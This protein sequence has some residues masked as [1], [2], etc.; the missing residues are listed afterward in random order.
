MSRI[1]SVA[2]ILD[3]RRSQKEEVEMEAK[4]AWQALRDEEEI[5]ASIEKSLSDTKESLVVLGSGEI[6]NIHQLSLYY[7]YI[8]TLDA[9]ISRQLQTI[10]IKNKELEAVQ[11]R[12]VEAYRDMKM[13]ETLKAR[14]VKEKDKRLQKLETR[15]LDSIWNSMVARQ[16]L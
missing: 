14:L 15:Q 16:A 7:E 8:N 4:K 2:R 10:L 11:E 6:S 12:L 9:K 5:L 3:F 13:V 1:S